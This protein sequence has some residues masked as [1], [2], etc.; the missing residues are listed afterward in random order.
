[1]TN[2][3]ARQLRRILRVIPEIADG[4]EHDIDE[5]SKRAGVEKDVLLSDLKSLADHHGAPGG[6]IEGMQ[7]YI[8]PDTVEVTSDHFLR[9]MGLTLQELCALELGLAMLRAERPPD[10]TTA[11][12]RTRERLREVI[13][14][15][16]SDH[17]EPA[18]RHAEIA[19]TE[20]LPYLDELR[21]ALR[22][23]R[24]A[25]ITYRRS[26]SDE[27]STRVVRLYAIVPA[28]GMWY[29]VAY[30]ESS[31]GLRVFRMDRVE[32]ASA[33]PDRY[34]IPAGF[35]VSETLQKGK[36]LKSELPSAGMKVRYSSRIARWIAEREGVLADADGSLTIE[37]PLA[38]AE[39]GVRH[40][41]Q[42]GP[43][44][45]VLEPANLRE[46]IVKR[47]EMMG[48]SES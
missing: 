38:D 10:E 3:A 45:E 22:D 4:H 48:A 18:L 9:P 33:L 17:D 40:V 1:M 27:T 2:T 6:F 43:D 46:D 25:K 30:C 26:G 12:E 11:I 5:I 44:A 7:I 21:K 14:R 15:L 20:G 13:A 36:G 37:H 47:L 23:H 8:G 28:S 24:K 29:A 39:W 41:L 32:D 35:S 34:E 31:E 16:P 19:P 42:Y